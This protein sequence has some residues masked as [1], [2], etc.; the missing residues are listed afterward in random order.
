MLVTGGTGLVGKRFVQRAIE[1]E[2]DVFVGIHTNRSAIGN[3]VEFD[4]ANKEKIERAFT[5]IKPEAV[6]HLAAFT[7]VDGCERDRDLAQ[8]INSEA[9]SIIAKQAHNHDSFLVHVS[10]DY[11]FDGNQGL[12]SEGD[13]PNPINW[14]GQTKL[15]AEQLVTQEGGHFCVARISTP[16]GLHERR[17]SFPVFVA[18][19]LQRKQEV[20]ALTDQYTSPSHISNLADMLIAVLEQRIGGILHLASATRA[21]RFEVAQSVASK[22]NLDRSLIIPIEMN[23]MNWIAKRP[24]DSSLAVSLCA[25]KT[26]VDPWTLEE[27]ISKLTKELQA[28]IK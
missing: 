12:Y 3:E 9:S 8:K 20:R 25:Q 4:L 27:G 11:V 19:Q 23:S 2:F 21:S 7:D 26:N 24:K 18:K 14:Y 13:E 15:K 16:F 28:D 5:K 6:V 17:T 10:T 1:K 22:M